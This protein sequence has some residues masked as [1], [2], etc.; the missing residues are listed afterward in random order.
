MTQPRAHA[1][2]PR[3]A[4]FLFLQ[5]IASPF[6]SVLGSALRERGHG[7]RRIN[8]SAGD[9][10][11]WPFPA[12]HYRGKRDGWDA[13]LEAYIRTHAVTD[14][15]LFGDCRP[16]HQAAV[17]VA[18]PMGVRIHVFEEG[19]IRPYWITC[20]AGGVNGNSTLPKRAEEIR[21]LA[22]KLPQPGR[23]M[24]LTG[25][26]GRR[27][28]WDIGFNIANIG[29]PYLYPGFRT[30]RP[31][32]IA[33]EY[34]GWIRKF[35]RRR[36]T[37]REAARVNEIYHAINADYFLLPLQLDSD[38]QIRVHSPFLGVEGFMD[39]VIAS[40]AKHSQ[41]PTRLLVKLHPLDSGIMNWRKR[42]RQSAKRHGCNDRLDFIDGGDL[43]KLIDGSRGV[44]LVNSTVGM[45]ALERGRPTLAFGSAVYNLPGLTH[46]GDIDT[47]WSAP[48]GPDAALMQDF[49]RVVMHRTQINGGYFSR[50]AIERAVAGAVPRLEAAL[51]P[52]ALAAA[53]DTLEQ[54]GRDE[55][56]S[57]A[58]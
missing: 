6:F 33:A 55:S 47:F 34:A 5:G 19:Y 52:A 50:S 43:P 26:M 23:A 9:W 3:A 22:R 31:N 54:A 41:A 21:E 18:K 37:R 12:D 53:R 45:L 17:L 15:V 25:D 56:L 8:F 35:V 38:Y 46:Q 7:V 20:E 57:P 11:F 4:T 27:S 24:P 13:Y 48:Q 39:R 1:I 29:F 36:R 49:F 10:L 2:G 40:F 51:P 14:I 44:V 30:H 32:H 42:A 16:Y 58:Y 28:L